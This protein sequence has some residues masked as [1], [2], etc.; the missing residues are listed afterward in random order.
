M[1]QK[2]KVGIIGGA[3]Y[4]GGELLR[5]LI[6]HPQVEIAFVNSKSN[7]GNPVYQVHADLIGETDL[8]FNDD[9][10]PLQD[11]SIDVLFLCV[12]H[13]DARKFLTEYTVNDKIKII[14][15]SQD[16]RLSAKSS[17]GNR[18]FIYGLPELN[19]AAIRTAQNIANPGCFA[20]GIQLGLLPLAKAGLLQSVYT[21][22]IT[23][24]T[25]AGQGLSA[26]SHFSWR[27]NNIQAYKTLTHQHLKEITQSI[28]QL[29]SSFS[30]VTADGSSEALSFIPWRGDFTRGIFISSLIDCDWKIE[31]L[32]ELF[33]AFYQ[34]APFT[35]LSKNEIFLKQVVNTNKCIIQLEK[36]GTKVVV[37]SAIDNLTKGASGQAVQ[38]MNLI[39][40]LDE[41]AGLR[42]KANYF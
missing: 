32:T 34:D 19:K 11:G 37:H 18:Q 26:T 42:L 10:S 1:S 22:G 36:V 41:S 38:N 35:V 12:G 24:S 7:T 39:F 17:I 31:Q 2:I 30:P 29:Q 13:G 3:G 14:D 9:L 6:N 25:G 23:G 28:Q 40:G 21:T 16:F 27:A 5:L 33:T 20:T 15:L 4:T 8:Q